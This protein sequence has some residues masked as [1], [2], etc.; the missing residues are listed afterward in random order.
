MVARPR[1]DATHEDVRKGSEC[2]LR[3]FDQRFMVEI[4]E[5][6]QDHIRVSFPASDY[7]VEGMTVDL[8]FHDKSGCNLYRSVV[9]EGPKGKRKKE[10]LLDRPTA[11]GRAQ[12][13]DSCRVNTDLTVQVKDQV[14]TRRYDAALRDL[15][16]GGALLETEAPF[17]FD[18][19]V[20]MT[21][22]LPG[23]LAHTILGR[24]VHL[25]DSEQPRR[26]KRRLVGIEF[27]GIEP[28][29][30]ETVSRYIWNRLRTLYAAP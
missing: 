2:L 14:R 29:V 16:C 26:G 21:L 8:E 5:V 13:R 4:L 9:R 6:S 15:S 28:H 17:D 18:T 20:E 24:V 10:L 12:H 1:R 3:V 30:A 22:S 7:P 19:T 23:E 27:V 25:T 11:L